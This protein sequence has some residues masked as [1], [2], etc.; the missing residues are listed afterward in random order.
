MK[1]CETQKLSGRAVRTR[2]QARYRPIVAADT[3]YPGD[4]VLVDD[5]ALTSIRSRLKDI[6]VIETNNEG[7][8]IY[9]S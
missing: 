3:I 5:T 4:V 9:G 8:P 7:Q 2:D 6:N 1:L